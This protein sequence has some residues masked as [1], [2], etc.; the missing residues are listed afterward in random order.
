[1]QVRWILCFLCLSVMV[2]ASGSP[3]LPVVALAQVMPVNSD[4]EAIITEA[5]QLDRQ[6]GQLY[7]EGRYAE[8]IAAAQQALALRE[9]ALDPTHPGIATSL[10]NLAV[11]Y[12]AQGDYAQAEAYLL[13]ALAIR[14][15]SLP[16]EHPHIAQNFNNL[17]ALYQEQGLYEE[18]EA[19]H[20]RA[21]AIRERTLPAADPDLA[22]SFNN[23]ALLYRSQGRYAEAQPYYLR[24]LTILEQALPPNHPDL[25]TILNNL[26]LLYQYQGKYQDA[27]DTFLRA[28]AI[29]NQA[30]SPH[31][32][33]LAANLNN[34]A[35]LY[36]AQGRY[37]EALP[38]YQQALAILERALP[39]K[40]P[41][42]ATSLNNLAGIYRFL[43]QNREA[44]HY[45]SR[46]L[47][48]REQALPPNHPDLA[49]SFNSLGLL[50]QGQGQ[51]DQAETY[52]RQAL[53]IDQ[54]SLPEN[55][56][57]IAGDLNNLALLYKVQR[58][59]AKAETYLLQSL[60]IYEKALPADHP[61]L[62]QSLNNLA[63]LYMAQGKIPQSLDALAQ[64]LDLE[65]T[66]LDL[67]LA[68]G[69][70]TRKRAFLGTLSASTDAVLSLHLQQAAT[71]P[72]AARLALTTVFRR[73]GRV[74]DATASG[75]QALRQ[76]LSVDDQAL[77][78]NLGIAQSQLASLLYSDAG[79]LT[80]PAY[81]D[82][83]SQLQSQVERLENQLARR[84]A[85]FRVALQPVTI[86]AIQAQIPADAALIELVHYAPIEATAMPDQ[87]RGESRYAV[88][89][90]R[91][92]GN[93]QWIDL[94]TAKTIDEQ[95]SKLRQDLA[96]RRF[97][98]Q[99]SSR[100]LYRLLMQPILAQ[101]GDTTHLLISP[102][103]ELN[104][105]P[106]A[107]LV[108]EQDR[109]LIE[110]YQITY[111]T[112]GRDLLKLNTSVPSQQGPVF[113]ANPNYDQSPTA[114]ITPRTRSSERS[115]DLASLQMNPLPGT[116]EEVEAIAATLPQAQVFTATQAT[117]TTLKQ[118]TSPSILHLATHG[119][120]LRAPSA[121]LPDQ[122]NT[123]ENP[124]LRS[125]LALAGFNNR[126]SGN[127]DGVLTALEVS[128]L[129]LA[130]TQLVV[131]S[132]CETGLGD[133]ANGEGVYGLRR[134]FALAGAHSQLMSLWKV[135]D[136]GTSLLMQRYYQKLAAGMER[137]QALRQVQL[138]MSAD[139]EYSHPYYWAAFILSGDWRAIDL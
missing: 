77:F 116:Q 133:V 118:L 119:F 75:R 40:H 135:D 23:L 20:L 105:I 65:E 114:A 138:E 33:I 10:N 63:L 107:A 31:H 57:N 69:S 58:E 45:A 95:V 21:L 29:A 48:I 36:D 39:P 82:Q 128:G 11:L 53:T 37:S 134:A 85:E 104:L 91:S 60:A 64:S 54:Q 14:E 93:P 83:V 126:Q 81:R 111:L 67:N 129:N 56:P 132:A 120:F 112:T 55:H 38:Y 121:T 42:I 127:E 99:A 110:S 52:F 30:F 51:Y 106:F 84:S 4:P 136:Y 70:D 49:D 8:A 44:L 22:Q 124:L 7:Q 97:S 80:P 5:E 74:L 17:A 6:V 9:Q 24:A 96:T 15:Q 117:E 89:V 125:G 90:L 123:A 100:A 32:P 61:T 113:F 2:T 35:L 137:S 98:S 103:S 46:A 86:D 28:L 94:G 27:E 43:G 13:R 26:G 92:Q 101:L 18:A 19:Y 130:G 25:A 34:L 62:A 131:L 108:D 68:L 76:Q 41:D 115:T 66:I 88:Y 72:A 59:F 47:G 79:Q 102:D 139:S 78:D 3:L 50:A 109:Y 1:M 73:K 122:A 12:Q 87:Q 71:N 16:A